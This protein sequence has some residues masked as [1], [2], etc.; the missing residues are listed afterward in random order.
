MGEQNNKSTNLFSV[1]RV[2]FK[3]FQPL[4]INIFYL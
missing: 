3:Y 2:F 1:Y 4:Q